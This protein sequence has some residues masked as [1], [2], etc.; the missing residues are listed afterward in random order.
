MQIGKT[1][2]YFNFRLVITPS[3]RYMPKWRKLR[4]VAVMSSVDC[5]NGAGWWG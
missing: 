5:G 2:N 3:G 1:F 4:K